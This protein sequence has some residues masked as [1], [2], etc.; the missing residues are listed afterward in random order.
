MFQ[1]HRIG[2]TVAAYNEERQ[3]GLVLGTM[4]DFIDHIV[5]VDDGSSDGTAAAC[6][7][8]SQRLGERL[9]VVRHQENRGVG[10]AVTSGFGALLKL[11]V[12]IV[13]IMAG[14]G[15]CHPDDLPAL[16]EPIVCDEAD[17]A[18]GNRMFSG[19][20]WKKTPKVRYLGSAVLSMLTKIASGYWH[21]A[22]SQDGY[23]A[24]RVAALKRMNLD[25]LHQGYAFEN[26]YLIALNILGCRAVD[27]PM[28]P[29]YGIGERSSMRILRVIPQISWTLI[30]GFLNRLFAK[31]VIRDFHPLVFF[32]LFGA[33]LFVSGFGLGVAA[34][35]NRMVTGGVSAASVVLVALLMIS[36]LQL[37]LFGMWFDMEYNR[38]LGATTRRKAWETRRM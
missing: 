14:D 28:E 38:E 20:A 18:K 7:A 34:I 31:Y 21:L 2:V 37:L 3:I 8:W 11:D 1:G 5:I 35:V 12:D 25:A 10:G 36:G 24:T 19:N 4:P 26:S 15:Q 33:L 13:V 17:F 27:V 9:T 29:R 6:E 22:D 16:L 30:R 32:Y 23:S